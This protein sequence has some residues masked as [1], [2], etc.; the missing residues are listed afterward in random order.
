MSITKEQ[1][2]EWKSHPVTIE[3][4]KEIR[5]IK[6]ALERDLGLGVTISDNADIT[7]GMTNRIVGQVAGLNQLLNLEYE[8]EEKD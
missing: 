6:E 1:F 5:L 2:E 3:V 4:Y 8:D 7:Q